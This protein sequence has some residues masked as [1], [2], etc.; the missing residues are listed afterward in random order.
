[1]QAHLASGI[2]IAIGR[3]TEAEFASALSKKGRTRELA[4]GD[5]RRVLE[6][7]DAHVGTSFELLPVGSADLYAASRYL[8]R[9]DTALRTLDA[10]HAAIAHREG[11]LLATADVRLAEAATTL[12]TDTKLVRKG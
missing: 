2:D 12:D 9:F 4:S 3:L 1:V 5:A 11:M 7:F 6:V 10:V 8:R